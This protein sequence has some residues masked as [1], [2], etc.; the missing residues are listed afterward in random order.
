MATMDLD[1][2]YRSIALKDVA[3][4]QAQ[5]GL[6]VLLIFTGVAFYA[7]TGGRGVW[8]IGVV[9]ACFGLPIALLSAVVWSEWPKDDPE[10]RRS[11]VRRALRASLAVSVVGLTLATWR[12]IEAKSVGKSG[13]IV[14]CWI[15][16]LVL[17]GVHVIASLNH[18]VRVRRIMRIDYTKI[19]S[20]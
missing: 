17:C 6:G 4:G 7:M 3:H 5:L 20:N 11:F 1:A 15:V 13:T 8:G 2:K 12:V 14:D 16:M 18:F 19:H 9:P 10:Q